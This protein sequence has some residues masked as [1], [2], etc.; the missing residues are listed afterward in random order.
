MYEYL[1]TLHEFNILNTE[2]NGVKIH[3]KRYS[4]YSQKIKVQI[5]SIQLSI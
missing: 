3:S 4:F 1:N 5:K 2:R